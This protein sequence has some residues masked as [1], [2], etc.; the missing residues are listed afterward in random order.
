MVTTEHV[1]DALR[2]VE[3]PE[4]KRDIVDLGMVRKVR[5]EGEQVRLTLALTT[6]NCPLKED[7]KSVV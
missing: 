1:V 5:V 2:G 4:L 6:L 7:R 3:D